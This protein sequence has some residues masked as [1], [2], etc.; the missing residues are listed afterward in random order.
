MNFF[1]SS[2]SFDHTIPSKDEG[3]EID[4]LFVGLKQQLEK[5]AQRQSDLGDEEK[6]HMELTEGTDE[7]IFMV[8]M[9]EIIV[10]VSAFCMEFVMLSQYLK[11]RELI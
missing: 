6:G 5:F 4:R 8:T 11:R 1:Y 10:I 3:A 7:K 2:D 9:I